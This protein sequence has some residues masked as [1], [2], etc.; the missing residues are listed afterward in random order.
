MEAASRFFAALHR[1]EGAGLAAIVAEPVPE[2]GLGIAIMDRLRRAAAG[3][4]SV[5]GDRVVWTR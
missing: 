1:L 3:R 5:Q 4:A 2:E